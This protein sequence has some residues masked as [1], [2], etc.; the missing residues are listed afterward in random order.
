MPHQG[1]YMDFTEQEIKDYLEILKQL[2][3]K[4]S[5]SVIQQIKSTIVS[6]II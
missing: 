2:I 4:G 3:L 6:H 1:K 5:Y